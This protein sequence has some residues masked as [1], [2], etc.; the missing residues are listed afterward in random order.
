MKARVLIVDDE[1]LVLRNLR[2]F[3]EDEGMSVQGVS[4]AEDAVALAGTD[5]SFQ[6]CIMDMR[7][8]GM[9]GNA[10]IR[11]LHRLRPA[12]R[13]LI[14]TG[15]TGYAIPDDLR[16]LGIDEGHLF[17]KP[18]SDMAPIARRASALSGA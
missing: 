5:D 6:V 17:R 12:M 2:A 3:L 13:F 18:L 11:E 1:P 8:P 9:D 4:S 15:S 14:H 7:L 10:A 16:A